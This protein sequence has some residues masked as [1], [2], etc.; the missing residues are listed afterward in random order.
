MDGAHVSV[1]VDYVFR[2]FLP[3]T[4]MTDFESRK[5]AIR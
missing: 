3:M 5:T 4:H 2:G 1:E